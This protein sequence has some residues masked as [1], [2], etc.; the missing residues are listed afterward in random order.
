MAHLPVV[1]R[2]VLWSPAQR[3]GATTVRP[4]WLPAA[5]SASN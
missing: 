5:Q 4:V 1:R 3:A 2:P